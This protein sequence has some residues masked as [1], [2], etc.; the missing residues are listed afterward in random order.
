MEL[1]SLEQ[2]CG[3]VREVR[4]IVFNRELACDIHEKGVSDFVTRA[5]TSVQGFIHER[6]TSLC[7][8]CRFMG[9]EST[10][11]SIDSSVPTF[12][13]DP[14]DGT[15]NFIHDFRLS[16]VSLALTLHGETVK[17][18]VYNPF[19]DEM[20]S[21]ES[22]GGAFLNGKAIHVSEVPDIAH[23]LVCIG[24]MP[25]HK[26]VSVGY[27]GLFRELFMRSVD[28]RRLGSSAIEACYVAAG[29]LDCYLE[30]GLGPWDFAATR[31]I[32]AE[33]GGV[34]SDWQGKPVSL[35]R[36]SNE[37][38]FSN[39]RLHGEFISLIKQYRG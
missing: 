5:D 36:E 25:Y 21:A 6:L 37:I 15:T 20:F 26:D 9:E 8:D 27:F 32:I 35:D 19:T 18:V 4:P 1:I 11:H 2:L 3:L 24:T 17:A 29:R 38:A 34:V 7:P 33:A 31:L 12:V 23:A 10:D 28:I 22:G 13:L 30:N 14:I 16:A 39:G